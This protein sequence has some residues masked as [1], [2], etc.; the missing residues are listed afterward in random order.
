[1]PDDEITPELVAWAETWDPRHEVNPGDASEELIAWA[2]TW[3][4][5]HEVAIPLD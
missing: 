3:D 4:P 1:M 5:R 2:A